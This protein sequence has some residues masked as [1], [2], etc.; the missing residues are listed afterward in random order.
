MYFRYFFL[1]TAYQQTKLKTLV[2]SSYP[3]RKIIN[4]WL[5]TWLNTWK[6]TWLNTWLNTWH[7]YLPGYSCYRIFSRQTSDLNPG[8]E[9]HKLLALE[10]HKLLTFQKSNAP[11]PYQN[12]KYFVN[13]TLC[14]HSLQPGFY[15][16]IKRRHVT[17]VIYRLH[18][19]MGLWA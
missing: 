5:N 2:Q 14:V 19:N 18:D 10:K 6:N 3:T 11:D 9:K 15:M 8:R 1:N 7:M 17:F 12:L 13:C 4:T 16:W